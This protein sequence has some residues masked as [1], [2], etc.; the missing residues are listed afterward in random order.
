MYLKLPLDGDITVT[1]RIREYDHKITAS[2]DWCVVDLLVKKP[3][4]LNYELYEDEALEGHEV[5]KIKD[6]IEATINEEDAKAF[7][8]LEPYMVFEPGKDPIHLIWKIYIWSGVEHNTDSTIDLY[9]LQE[10]MEGLLKYLKYTTGEYKIESVRDLI[11]EGI[12]VEDDGKAWR[13]KQLDGSC[14]YQ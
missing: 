2:D 4:V 9:L 10:D 5:R 12:I 14:K 13:Q 11:D 8:P 3:G 7:E 1:F 6:L